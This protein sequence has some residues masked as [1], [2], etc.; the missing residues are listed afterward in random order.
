LVL[1]AAGVMVRPLTAA[2]GTPSAHVSAE[3]PTTTGFA[4]VSLNAP[5]ALL[6]PAATRT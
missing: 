2:G 1:S 6:V 3:V 5:L 4:V